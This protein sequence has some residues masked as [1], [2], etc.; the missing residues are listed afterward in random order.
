MSREELLDHLC[1]NERVELDTSSCHDFYESYHLRTGKRLESQ[2]KSKSD[3]KTPPKNVKLS[4]EANTTPIPLPEPDIKQEEAIFC[5]MS[6]PPA[7]FQ[8]FHSG[9]LAKDFDQKKMKNFVEGHLK[10]KS[11]QTVADLPQEE[12]EAYTEYRVKE[13]GFKSFSMFSSKTSNTTVL[14]IWINSTESGFQIFF[15]WLK[16]LEPSGAGQFFFEF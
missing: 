12:R 3:Q 15:S 14:T 1:L 11:V 10:F 16:L 9:M 6:I 7:P 8:P 4:N 13:T 5:P 2:P